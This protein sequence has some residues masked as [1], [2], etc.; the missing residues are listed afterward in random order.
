MGKT[1]I[2]TESADQTK[3]IGSMYAKKIKNG[4]LLL[5]Y[6]NLG[7]GKTTFA[8]GFAQELGITRHISSPTFLLLRSYEIPQNTEGKFYHFDLYRLEN[9]QGIDD[10]GFKEILQ[11]S[12]NIVVVEWADKLTTS[13]LLKST[14]LYFD[15]VGD[16]QRTIVEK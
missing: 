13:E 12:R 14:K 6:G 11:N 15:Y 8:Q 2:Q 5:L 9:G 7:S 10:L 1:V 4:G 3:K 16:D